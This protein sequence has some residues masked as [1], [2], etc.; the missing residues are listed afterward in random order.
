MTE[1]QPKKGSEWLSKAVDLTKEVRSILFL[2][3]GLLAGS[4]GTWAVA[5]AGVSRA[6]STAIADSTARVRV[7][8][9]ADSLQAEIADVRREVMEARD[10]QR[11]AFGALMKAIPAF[12]KAVQEQ[13]E[14]N[15]DARKEKAENE[16][17][18]ENLNGGTP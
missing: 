5:D 1:K 16:Q 10:E 14:A 11:S 15:V 17:M 13:G 12:K 6:E 3:G 8:A 2:L 9:A 4:G 18:L 7:K